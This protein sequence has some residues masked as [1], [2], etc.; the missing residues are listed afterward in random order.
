MKKFAALLTKEKQ[1]RMNGKIMTDFL[2]VSIQFRTILF[3]YLLVN[4][5][6]KRCICS[7]KLQIFEQV[8]KLNIKTMTLTS[9]KIT[10]YILRMY[11]IPFGIKLKNL[12]KRK[13]HITHHRTPNS[14]YMCIFPHS[15]WK[16]LRQPALNFTVIMLCAKMLRSKS[17]WLSLQRFS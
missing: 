2:R 16:S 4:L 13:I 12:R 6:I 1:V 7:I 8:K 15:C 11:S 10:Y 14:I 5:F 3:S 17:L 9:L